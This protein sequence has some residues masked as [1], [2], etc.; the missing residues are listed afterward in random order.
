MVTFLK[1]YEVLCV[2]LLPSSQ[3]GKQ[4]RQ[5]QWLAFTFS[6]PQHRIWYL[7]TLCPL[8]IFPPTQKELRVLTMTFQVRTWSGQEVQ[9]NPSTW[10]QSHTVTKPWTSCTCI[11]VAPGDP[12]GPRM[13]E[14]LSVWLCF[15]SPGMCL[16]RVKLNYTHIMCSTFMLQSKQFF[17]DQITFIERS[18]SYKP[19][20]WF[21]QF[22][23][24]LKTFI[25]KLISFWWDTFI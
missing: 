5:V 10:E 2:I 1:S 24:D 4:G 6:I 17:Q 12:T 23:Q 21:G 14:L 3:N 7:L 19:W 18:T 22:F 20:T 9:R 8:E 11:P 25:S 16:I 15:I 13:K